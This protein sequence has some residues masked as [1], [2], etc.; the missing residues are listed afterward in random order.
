MVKAKLTD[1]APEFRELAIEN[2]YVTEEPFYVPVRNE[3]EL[4]ASA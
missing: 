4:F 1:T 3:T 2:Y